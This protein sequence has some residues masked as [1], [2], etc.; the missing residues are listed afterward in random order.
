[1]AGVSAA[2]GSRRYKFASDEV[3]ESCGNLA[4]THDLS[5]EE[6]ALEYERLMMSRCAAHVAKLWAAEAYC[7]ALDQHWL[8]AIVVYTCTAS[9]AQLSAHAPSLTQ[10]S[11][12]VQPC[13][14][15]F[16]HGHAGKLQAIRLAKQMWMR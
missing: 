3:E 14:T 8:F 12:Y 4:M 10:P 16:W 1:M 7:P 11:C 6:L 13:P 9:A 5:F 15:P 2:F